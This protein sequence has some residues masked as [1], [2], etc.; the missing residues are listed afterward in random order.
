MLGRRRSRKGG[1][2]LF[3]LAMLVLA[4]LGGVMVLSLVSRVRAE[5]EIPSSRQAVLVMR[6]LAYDA[7]LKARAKDTIDIALL[8]RKGHPDSERMASAMA[9]AF[10]ALEAT[11]V[12]GLPI[13][14]SSHPFASVDALKKY[15][16][17]GG[18]DL[19]YVCRGLEVELAAITEV[20]R[21]SKVLTVGSA[22]E[23]V[24]KGLSLGVFEID[25]K[26]T[27]LLNLT[28]SR[29]EGAAFTADLLRLAKVIR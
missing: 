15:F 8:H 21:K 10:G 11:Q 14:V 2:P 9:R 4:S 13:R 20:T 23:Q 22:Q 16:D 18:V 1:L 17:D 25:A 27:I 19:V 3:V 24:K 26:C 6:A 28:A 29:L 12:S 7:N 5:G